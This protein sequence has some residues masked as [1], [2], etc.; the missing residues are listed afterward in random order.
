MSRIDLGPFPAEPGYQEAVAL[1]GADPLARFRDRY[2]FA[3]DS[4]I[5]L[6]GNSL[7]R[8]PRGVP[9]RLGRVV[10]Q[11]WG[12]RLI[13]SWNEGWWDL[14]VAVGERIAPLIGAG[15]GEVIV[16][17]S[18]SVNLYKLALAGLQALPER[19]RIVTD[20][21]NFP[22][23][24]YILEAA[25]GAMGGEHEV[26]VVGSDG[27]E[28][29]VPDLIDALD[30]RVALLSLSHTTFKSGYLYDMTRL[31]RAAHDAGA[32]ALWDLSHSVGAVP[33]DLE[34]SGADLA[35][36]CTYKYLSG[37]PGSPAFLYVRTALQDRLRNPITGWWGHRAPFQ[38]DLRF[39][40]TAGIRRFHT[41]TM[42][43]LS[44]TAIEEGVSHLLEAG[45]ETVREKSVALGRFMVEQA[46]EF[47]TPFGF[48]L[49]SPASVEARGSHLAY[50]HAR[51]WAVTR[52]LAAEAEVI[53]DFR[54]PDSIR[55]GLAPLYVGFVDV[56]TAV[57]RVR[58]L[59]EE[60][61]H[62]ACGEER[63]TVT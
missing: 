7:G 21:L 2:L 17:D 38:F 9:E 32:L 20:D 12:R 11:E 41:G 59:V 3:D 42:P 24:V 23:D 18:T 40:Q 46:A 47:L 48:R 33:V 58:R 29:P 10:E 15:P 49:A 35:V 63:S 55:F 62:L 39:D 54:T 19:A 1:D 6:D 28:G 16:S 22:G 25:A 45:M 57:Q 14:H 44:L 50:S 5:Y 37:G 34:A 13:R 52:A 27:V 31:T 36:G 51:A 60:G 61:R 26:V 4:L 56:H 43:I 30:E 8:L 53:P